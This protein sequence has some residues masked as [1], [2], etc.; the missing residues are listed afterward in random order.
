M[1]IEG[2]M[3]LNGDAAPMARG[4]EINKQAWPEMAPCIGRLKHLK[5]IRKRLVPGFP[6]GLK[7]G[8]SQLTY[9]SPRSPSNCNERGL[10]RTE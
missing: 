5:S 6:G 1:W 4:I 9:R 2:N 8:W 7:M 3:H 10:Q